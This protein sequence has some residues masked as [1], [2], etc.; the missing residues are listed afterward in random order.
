MVNKNNNNNNSNSPCI[1]SKCA[2]ACPVKWPRRHFF[3]VFFL[4]DKRSTAAST[5]FHSL[6]EAGVDILLK[7]FQAVTCL[8]E[9]E[10]DLK[11]LLLLCNNI[12]K[13]NDCVIYPQKYRKLFFQYVQS[14]VVVFVCLVVKFWVSR[15]NQEASFRSLVEFIKKMG[16]CFSMFTALSMTDVVFRIPYS[17]QITI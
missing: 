9:D 5:K 17:N 6:L 12:F 7:N 15:W 10:S 16:G 2:P 14:M 13:I 1:N 4:T 8:S 3:F 11:L